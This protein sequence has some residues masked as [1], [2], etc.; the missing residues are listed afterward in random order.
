MEDILM[1]EMTNALKVT[2]KYQLISWLVVVL[3]YLIGIYSYPLLAIGFIPIAIS[4][5]GYLKYSNKLKEDKEHKP[6]FFNIFTAILWLF[7]TI[8]II[9]TLVVLHDEFDLLNATC[10]GSYC[11]FE[12]FEFILYGLMLISQMFIVGILKT[13]NRV[14]KK[15]KQR[16]EKNKT[17]SQ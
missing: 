13:L 17:E 16:K 11:M 6:I 3:C 7:F 8:T 14:Y 2:V 5:Y 1:K 9:I 10:K 12:G 4:T 15:Q